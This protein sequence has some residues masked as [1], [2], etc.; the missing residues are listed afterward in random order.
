MWESWTVNVLSSK[1]ELQTKEEET[2]DSVAQKA[3]A[4]GPLLLSHLKSIPDLLHGNKWQFVQVTV[5]GPPLCVEYLADSPISNQ[6]IPA[7]AYCGHQ[8]LFAI[9]S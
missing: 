8:E 6:S 2:W 1:K 4:T 5:V 7:A 9:D 3:V